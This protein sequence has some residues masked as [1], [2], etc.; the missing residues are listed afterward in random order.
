MTVGRPAG[1]KGTKRPPTTER[2][3]NCGDLLVNLMPSVVVRAVLFLVIVGRV[4]VA[5]QAD[6]TRWRFPGEARRRLN[7][8]T[9]LHLES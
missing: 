8:S 1:Q 2:S 9:R 6:S 7:A 3:P 4:L 5:R